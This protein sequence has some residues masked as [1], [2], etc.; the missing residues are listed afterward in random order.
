[1]SQSANPVSRDWRAFA[2]VIIDMQEAFYQRGDFHPRRDQ[3]ISN[4]TKLLKRARQEG[5]DVVHLREIHDPEHSNWMPHQK[6]RGSAW[7][8]RGTP[9]ALPLPGCG[10]VEGEPVFEKTKLDGWMSADFTSHLVETGKRCVSLPS[11]YFY[12]LH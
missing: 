7:P 11:F 2:L 8:Q 4:V 5:L 1:M 6:L 9:G 3:V 10:E 12:S